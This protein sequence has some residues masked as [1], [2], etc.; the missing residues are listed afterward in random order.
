ML[1]SQDVIRREV[2]RVHDEEGNPAIQL[3]YDLCMYGSRIGYTVI[4]EGILSNKK[5][6]TMVKKLID[7]FDG[8]VDVYYFDIPFEETLRRHSSKSNSH[9]FGKKEMAEWWKDKDY[10]GIEGEHIINENMT[11]DQ[12]VSLMKSA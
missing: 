9:E 12:I 7:D 5:Y 3:I 2:L 6:G 11:K 10:L 1:V 8:D 4:L